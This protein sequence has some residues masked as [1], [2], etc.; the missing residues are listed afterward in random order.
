[1]SLNKDLTIVGHY[2]ITMRVKKTFFLPVIKVSKLVNKM[3]CDPSFFAKK[4]QKKVEDFNKKETEKANEADGRAFS[5]LS[6]R[7][8]W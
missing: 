1:M 5:N 8:Q 3:T 2:C 7:Y 4:Y 6:D